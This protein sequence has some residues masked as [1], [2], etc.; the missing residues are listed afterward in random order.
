MFLRLSNAACT[1]V[2]RQKESPTSRILDP[3]CRSALPLNFYHHDRPPEYS[4]PMPGEKGCG[5]WYDKHPPRVEAHEL[6]TNI[7]SNSI[8]EH[9]RIRRSIYEMFEIRS[10]RLTVAK[11]VVVKNDPG[12]ELT[13]ISPTL[14]DWAKDKGILFDEIISTRAAAVSFTAGAKAEVNTA[15]HLH[16]YLPNMNIPVALQVLRMPGMTDCVNEILL[17]LDN[18]EVLGLELSI[19]N[20]TSTY[21]SVPNALEPIVSTHIP[22][23]TVSR[24]YAGGSHI[25]QV[26]PTI[27]STR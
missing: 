18:T 7:V 13:L 3:L 21:H 5:K 15:A 10:P 19:R 8:F 12:A 14:Y 22:F 26:H 27:S 20:R 23:E 16:V 24:Q 25:E 9:V 4:V 6:T 11:L 1:H 2:R 17:G